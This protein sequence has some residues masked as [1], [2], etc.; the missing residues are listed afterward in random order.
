[1]KKG[2]TARVPPFDRI[3]TDRRLIFLW[4]RQTSFIGCSRAQANKIPSCKLIRYYFPQPFLAYLGLTENSPAPTSR[5]PLFGTRYCPHAHGLDFLVLLLS[6]FLHIGYYNRSPNGYR[7]RHKR[8]YHHWFHTNRTANNQWR[9]RFLFGCFLL[10]NYI[11]QYYTT[12]LKLPFHRVVYTIRR[13]CK[14]PI[15]NDING[16]TEVTTIVLDNGNNR[17]HHIDYHLFVVLFEGLSRTSDSPFRYNQCM[18]RSCQT[19]Y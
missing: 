12:T 16:S 5:S 1:M 11:S 8:T 10:L 17:W 19:I 14:F 4:R 18:E 2:Y 7:C 3:S 6:M 13:M 15:L 9:H